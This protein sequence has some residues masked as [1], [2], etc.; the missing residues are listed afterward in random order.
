IYSA[1]S[2]SEKR[3]ALNTLASRATYAK[4]L[5]VSVGQ[6]QIASREITAEL[7][8]QLR[9]LKDEEIESQLTKVWGVARDSPADK[10]QEIEKYRAI[11]RAGGSQPGNALRGRV[12]FT[13]T[14]HQCHTLFNTGGKVG[15]DLTGSNR[16]DL[17]YVLPYLVE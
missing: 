5:L 4:A 7:V 13:K 8:R 3:D 6:N 10:Q 11:F 9:N 2:A 12:V 16:G 1:L 15:P 14:C 17:D